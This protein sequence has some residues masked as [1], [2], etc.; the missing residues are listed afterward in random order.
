[1][2]EHPGQLLLDVA[3]ERVDQ[4]A[5]A[6]WK[7]Q[8]A[9]HLDALIRRGL[10]FTTDDL[11]WRLEHVH[12]TEPRAMGPMIQNAAKDGR[13]RPSGRYIKSDRPECHRRPVAVWHPVVEQ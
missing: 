7:Q 10:P 4:A 3:L 12:T 1:M 2:T 13:I 8:C 9:V 6:S 5:D 11:W